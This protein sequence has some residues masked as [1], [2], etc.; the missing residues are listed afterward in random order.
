MMM[1]R[2]GGKLQRKVLCKDGVTSVRRTIA[3][4]GWHSGKGLFGMM[5]AI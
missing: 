1:D 4:G 3:F 2:R 5:M